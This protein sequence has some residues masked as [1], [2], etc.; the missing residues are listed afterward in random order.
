MVV[1]GVAA[2]LAVGCS[3]GKD[4]PTGYADK[5][6][7]FLRAGNDTSISPAGFTGIDC[8]EPNDDADGS[9]LECVAATTTAG[10]AWRF[11]FVVD[12]DDVVMTGVEPVSNA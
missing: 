9:P 8:D 4:G 2:T 6:E 10:V 5:A 7:Q 11:T 3:G 12:G 1:I